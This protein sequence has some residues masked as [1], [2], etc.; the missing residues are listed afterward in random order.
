[1]EYIPLYAH[2]TTVFLWSLEQP[3]ETSIKQLVYHV[4]FLA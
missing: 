1:V 4:S 2:S 3:K